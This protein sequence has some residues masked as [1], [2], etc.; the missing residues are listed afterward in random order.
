MWQIKNER[1]Y[2]K[3]NPDIISNSVNDAILI[4]KNSWNLEGAQTKDW[5]V[6][7]EDLFTLTL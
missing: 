1:N 4:D 3:L 6:K 7:L 5:I 2:T